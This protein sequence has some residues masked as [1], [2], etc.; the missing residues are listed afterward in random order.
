MARCAST[1]SRCRRAVA[2]TARHRKYNDSVEHSASGRSVIDTRL[3]NRNSSEDDRS[4]TATDAASRLP[5]RSNPRRYTT[6]SNAPAASRNGTRPAHRLMPNARYPSAVIQYARI[7]FCRRTA[8]SCS[9]SSQLP[10]SVIRT[11]DVM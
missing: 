5:D 7:G 2:A 8:P 6:T 4:A 10:D 1:E 3:N 11:A 9:G